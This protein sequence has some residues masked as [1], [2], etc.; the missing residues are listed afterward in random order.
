MA[1]VSGRK[2]DGIHSLVTEFVTT[3]SDRDIVQWEFLC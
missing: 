3:A 2:M 1:E